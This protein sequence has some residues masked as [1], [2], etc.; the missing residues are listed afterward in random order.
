MSTELIYFFMHKANSINQSSICSFLSF[1]LLVGKSL[2]LYGEWRRKT[3]YLLEMSLYAL[4]D[5]FGGKE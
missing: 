3:A 1:Y 4:L 5:S 2:I